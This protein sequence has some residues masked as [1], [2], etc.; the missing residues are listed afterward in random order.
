MMPYE[1][2]T[3]ALL[4]ITFLS[5]FSM[6]INKGFKNTEFDEVFIQCI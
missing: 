2:F 6:T 1:D 3:F 5:K 4:S